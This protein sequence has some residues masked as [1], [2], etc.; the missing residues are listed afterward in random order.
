MLDVTKKA[1]PYFV[2]MRCTPFDYSSIPFF[3]NISGLTLEYIRNKN[4]SELVN[5]A[6]EDFQKRMISKGRFQSSLEV[7]N[8]DSLTQFTSNLILQGELTYARVV[9]DMLN[10]DKYLAL[11]FV[12][13]ENKFKLY[14]LGFID[15]KRE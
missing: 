12:S 4:I 3:S 6:S 8:C 15:K 9:Y 14:D 11:V 13:E 7:I 1:R 2:D 5:A 10:T